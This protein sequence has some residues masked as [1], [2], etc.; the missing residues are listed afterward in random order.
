MSN[1]LIAEK[2]GQSLKVEIYKNKGGCGCKF[3]I[4]EELVKDEFYD[5]HDVSWA[6]SA[7]QNWIDGIKTLNG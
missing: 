5:R 7:A 1:T 3:Y 4:N 6:E 2:N